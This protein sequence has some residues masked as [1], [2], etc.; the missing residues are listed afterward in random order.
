MSVGS[1]HTLAMTEGGDL[2]SFGRGNRNVF[3]F[4][5]PFINAM[6]PLGHPDKNN[7]LL[8]KKITAFTDKSSKI[9][10]ISTGEHFNTVI[11]DNNQVYNWGRGEFSVFG[12]GS[13]SN[14]QLPVLN[15][16]F[17]YLRDQENLTVKKLQSRGNYSMAL[18]S[19][20]YLY[21][22]GSNDQGQ[23]GINETGGEMY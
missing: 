17:E 5:R 7:Q 11:T 1:N 12:N 20:G 13:N 22:W 6:G 14:R 18:M 9:I 16:H 21:G 23:M 2:W 10:S 8:P 19:D 3:L 4:F 15:S